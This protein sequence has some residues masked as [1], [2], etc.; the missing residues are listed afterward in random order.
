MERV[1]AGSSLALRPFFYQLTDA[2][3]GAAASLSRRPSIVR[4][5]ASV[6]MNLVF[7]AY[8]FFVFAPSMQAHGSRADLVLM[9]KFGGAYL[10]LFGFVGLCVRLFALVRPNKAASRSG[11]F[12]AN[13]DGLS[14]RMS[15]QELILPWKKINSVSVQAGLLVIRYRGSSAPLIVPRRDIEE[16]DALWALFDRHLTGV[17]GLI[18]NLDRTLIINTAR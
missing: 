6:T 2:E 3:S 7:G 1:D 13:Q 4:N 12:A 18:K 16:F 10:A 17:R 11:D 15:G 9:A 14:V 8:T 5:S